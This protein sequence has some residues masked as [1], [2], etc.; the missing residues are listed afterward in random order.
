MVVI[1]MVSEIVVVLGG[2]VDVKVVKVVVVEWMK[3]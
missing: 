3:G 2:K 1:D